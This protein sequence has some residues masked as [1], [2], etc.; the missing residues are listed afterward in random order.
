[1]KHTKPMGEK[2]ESGNLEVELLIK[3]YYSFIDNY[4][5]RRSMYK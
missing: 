5:Q 4:C 3:I 1:M 2:V